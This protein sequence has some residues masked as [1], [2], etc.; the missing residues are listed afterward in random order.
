MGTVHF[1]VL[2]QGRPEGLLPQL[3]MSRVM[4]RKSGGDLNKVL[5]S[6]WYES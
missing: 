4:E 5:D 2:A 6:N 1:P 3:D